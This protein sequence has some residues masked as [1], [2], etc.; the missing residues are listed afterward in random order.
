M[1]RLA[2]AKLAKADAERQLA[3]VEAQ[4]AV[5][6]G[7]I[8]E[9][10]T[11]F[12]DATAQKAKVE[13]DAA[14]CQSRLALAE[15]LVNGLSSENTRW[16]IEVA[17]LREQ[18]STLV[19]DS[20]LSAA[21]VSYIGSFGARM[22][23]ELWQQ[24]WLPDLNTRDIPVSEGVSPL[25]VLCNDTQRAE[26]QNEGLPADPISQENAAIVCNCYRWPLLI[27]P[28]LQGVKWLRT[29]H[30]QLSE[31]T[32]KAPLLVLQV[33]QSGWLTQLS[34]AI[35]AGTTVLLE[36]ISESLDAVL[37]PVLTRAVQKKG[38]QMFITLAGERVEYH[39]DFKL[40]LAT[41]LSNPHY[42]PEVAAACTLVN[43]IVTR[44]GL[45]EQLLA[46]IV[47]VEEPQ[48][49]EQRQAL[50]QAFNTYKIQ[51][52]RLEDQ[53]LERL[54]EA[55]AD[56][57]SD[58]ALI[59]GLEATKAKATEISAAVEAA[60]DTDVE[61]RQKCDAYR[62]VAVE[63][64]MLYF[65]L[66]ELQQV[67]HMYQYSLDSFT[68]LFF[69]AAATTEA[70][71]LLSDRVE[72]LRQ[73]L[74]IMVFTTV[75]RGLFQQHKLI[76]LAQLVFALISGGVVGTDCGCTPEALDHLLRWPKVL[77]LYGI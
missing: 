18:T 72:A 4:V 3:A 11:T 63:G 52:L 62:S 55:P 60:Q 42:P 22:R 30:V 67:D 32:E 71:D 64:S 45:E 59:T 8:V 47:A 56:I 15:R 12:L 41:K 50:T 54:A 58:V 43:F 28:Q 6:E 25:G 51:L 13:A 1:D 44:S 38:R 23:A 68:T 19:G 27:D 29:R 66:S 35:S 76:F 36:N 24:L 57:L 10:Q 40:Y 77:T 37:E 46:Q 16:G 9:L 7:R 17:K 74:R 5:V 20:L 49:Q 34:M 31:T 75:S 2:Q 65:L 39:P 33:S 26:W 70:R 53:L 69:K 21:F 73:M 14:Q 61:L 48:L